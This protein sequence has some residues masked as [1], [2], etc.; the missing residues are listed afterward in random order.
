MKKSQPTPIVVDREDCL[1]LIDDQDAH[2]KRRGRPKG[3]MTNEIADRI[4]LAAECLLAGERQRAMALK[5]FPGLHKEV[6]YTRTR[7]FF[8]RFKGKI[9]E[10]HRIR[11]LLLVNVGDSTRSPRPKKGGRP[12]GKLTDEVRERIER[13][14]AFEREHVSMR[15]MAQKLFPALSKDVAYDRTRD[16]F[17]RYKPQISEAR[18]LTTAST[19]NPP[20]SARP[21]SKN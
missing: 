16:L 14:V 18:R 15:K 3:K 9:R 19:A 7:Q 1:N 13:A 20:R 4:H 17:Y 21:P 5:L 2:S 11:G 12:S 10:E 6:A 8:H